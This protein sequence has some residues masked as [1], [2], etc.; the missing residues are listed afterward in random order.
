[1]EFVYTYKCHGPTLTIKLTFDCNENLFTGE[2]NYDGE[3]IVFCGKWYYLNDEVIILIVT[4][5]NGD[6]HPGV[7]FTL[8]A[9][10]EPVRFTEDDY[11]HKDGIVNGDGMWDS[12]LTVSTPSF[13]WSKLH[14]VAHRSI[15]GKMTNV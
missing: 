9:L 12:V 11:E 6:D 7:S 5:V 2:Y 10:R 14:R 15:K 4:S 8:C 13:L 3:H 1:M